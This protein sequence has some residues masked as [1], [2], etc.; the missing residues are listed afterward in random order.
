M[1]RASRV[2]GINETH[3]LFM[4]IQIDPYLDKFLNGDNVTFIFVENEGYS[5]F[6]EC[7]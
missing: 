7:V 6:P 1:Y 5:K 3:D 2:H 4:K